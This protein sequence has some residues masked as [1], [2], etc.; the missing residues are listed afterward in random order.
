MTEQTNPPARADRRWMRTVTGLVLGLT[1]MAVGVAC[2][3]P[4]SG[5]RVA[6]ANRSASASASASPGGHG[7]ALKF[8]QCMRANGIADWP[9]PDPNNARPPVPPGPPDERIRAATDKC[10]QYMPNGGEPPKTDPQQLEAMRKFAQCMRDNGIADYP[11]PQPN[12]GMGFGPSAGGG[13]IDPNSAQFKAAEQKCQ[14]LMPRP[15][16]AAG[17]GSAG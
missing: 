17:P 11:D 5:N 14:H 2:G 9:D 16:D 12:G 15:S 6:T 10:K 13:G 4:G 3:K 8:A 1:L 7:D